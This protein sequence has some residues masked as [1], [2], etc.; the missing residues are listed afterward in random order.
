MPNLQIYA[1]FS[2][3]P[4]VPWMSCAQLVILQAVSDASRSPAPFGDAGVEERSNLAGGVPVDP[5]VFPELGSEAITHK[6][7]GGGE[8]GVFLHGELQVEAQ[9]A[10]H[11][12]V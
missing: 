9:Y 11:S 5:A 4:R 6:H 1:D 7:G 8:E 10:R 2:W 12:S 3:M